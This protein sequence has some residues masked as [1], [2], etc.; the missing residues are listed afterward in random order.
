MMNKDDELLIIGIINEDTIE[1]SIPLKEVRS[2]FYDLIQVGPMFRTFLEKIEE[3]KGYSIPEDR[4]TMIDLPYKDVFTILKSPE[5]L[6]DA[7]RVSCRVDS[8]IPTHFSFNFLNKL[9][10][11]HVCL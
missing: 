7:P 5:Y 10:V 11:T 4:I 2:V 6:R 9:V 1:G 3:E 8:C